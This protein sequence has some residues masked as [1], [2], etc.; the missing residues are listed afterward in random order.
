M[1]FITSTYLSGGK[2]L[3]Q[4]MLRHLTR[5]PGKISAKGGYNYSAGTSCSHLPHLQVGCNAA[6]SSSSSTKRFF[7]GGGGELHPGWSIPEANYHKYT[8]QPTIPDKHF[9]IG[10]YNY[11]P[12]TLWLRSKRPT[13]ELVMT[14]VKDF[15]VK[16]YGSSLGP[17]VAEWDRQ[18]PGFGLKCLGVLGVLLGYNLFVSYVVSETD[19]YM[20]IEKLR[21]YEL[22]SKMWGS[23]FFLSESEDLEQR[24][25]KYN[26]KVIALEKLWDQAIQEA[27]EKR[28]FSELTKYLTPDAV[29]HDGVEAISDQFLNYRFN[30]MPYG[31]DSPDT[32]TFP[33]NGIDSPGSSLFFFG[34]VGSTGDYIERKD[35]KMAMLKKARHLYTN[36][37][38]PPTK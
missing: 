19:A 13:M 36:A 21:M 15:V 3:P 33:D 6:T 34:D 5:G 8:Y 9:Y 30:T 7:A 17:A 16:M 22:T 24:M 25:Q 11:A 31:R 26:M 37:Y 23:G 1:V 18:L 2:K 35:N 29:A 27:T 38:I 32:K 10:H 20:A 12:I 4:T 28:D 14:S